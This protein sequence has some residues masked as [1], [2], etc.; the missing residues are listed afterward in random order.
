M[1]FGKLFLTIIASVSAL[2]HMSNIGIRNLRFDLA[3]RQNHRRM[4]LETLKRVQRIGN[5]HRRAIAMDKLRE[6]V[7]GLNFVYENQ[8]TEEQIRQEDRRNRFQR[9]HLE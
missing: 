8:P 6:I 3:A 4:V 9:Y 1:N 7:N 2:G 5:P